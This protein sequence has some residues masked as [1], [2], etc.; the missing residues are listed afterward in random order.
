MAL[1]DFFSAKS[2][3]DAVQ[4]NSLRSAR[5][6][7]EKG[8]PPTKINECIILAIHS[9]VNMIE[10]LLEYGADVNHQ[11]IYGGKT[12]LHIAAQHGYVDVARFLLKHGARTDI[13]DSNGETPLAATL[14][15][16]HEAMSSALGLRPTHFDEKAFERRKQ[17]A[18]LI[19]EYE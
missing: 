8:V 18:S 6:L 2:L 5:R 4:R 13:V 15:S 14:Q 9:G 3:E 19:K 12:S 7:L 11:N 16:P 10:L 1:F 17:I